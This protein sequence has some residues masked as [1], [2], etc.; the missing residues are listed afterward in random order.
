MGV[1]LRAL[2]RARFGAPART[3]AAAALA[4]A[5]RGERSAEGAL[6]VALD[7]P[8]DGVQLAA[9]RALAVLGGTRAARELRVRARVEADVTRRGVLL[10]A[11]SAAASSVAPELYA[12]GVR[13]LV[14][15]VHGAPPAARPELDVSLPDGRTLRVRSAADGTT[16]IPDVPD[17][18]LSVMLV[19]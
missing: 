3:R 15:C 5:A 2:L 19:P 14:V 16:F 11:S 12:H 4:L 1:R 9:A 10:A 18:E 6:L 13:P 7:D 8:A 17:Q